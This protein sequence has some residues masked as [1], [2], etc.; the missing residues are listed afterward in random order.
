MIAVRFD[1]RSERVMTDAP[2]NEANAEAFI[3]FAVVRRGVD[4]E[5][6]TKRLARTQPA[7][8]TP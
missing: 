5:F 8:G 1:D 2:L 6:Y 3:K 7:A 4:E